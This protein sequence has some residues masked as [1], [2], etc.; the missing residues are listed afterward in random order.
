MM[1]TRRGWTDGLGHLKL[2][3]IGKKIFIINIKQCGWVNINLDNL[4]S[5]RKM[6]SFNQSDRHINIK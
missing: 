5:L 3:L 6:D 1:S 4:T 2:I